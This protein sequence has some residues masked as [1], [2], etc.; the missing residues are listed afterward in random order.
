MQQK[1]LQKP[2]LSENPGVYLFWSGRK[3]LYIGKAGNLKQRLNSYWQKNAGQK[4]IL[5]LAE[6]TRLELQKTESEIEA[7][8]IEAELIKKYRP[9]Y[10]ILMRDDKNYFYV[11][12]TKEIFP[13]IF[14]T[15][16][17]LTK[18]LESRILNLE[19]KT[20]NHHIHFPI[21]RFQIPDSR[22]IGPFTGGTALKTTLKLLRRIF[23]YCTCKKPHKRPC[24]NA[25]IGRCLGYCCIRIYNLQPT[26]NNQNEYQNNIQNIIA[27]LMGKKQK[28]LGK[29]KKEMHDAS[30]LEQYEIARKLRDQIAGL[31]DVFA[32]KKVL[33]LPR[34]TSNWPKLQHK[35]QKLFK[36]K[37]SF[38]RIEAYDISNI[39]GTDATG[40]MI[41]FQKGT[42]NKN[43]YRKFKIKSVHGANDVAMIK[44]VIRRRMQH[45]EWNLPTLIVIDGGKP[46]LRTA[47]SQ[48]TAYNL[49]PTTIITALAKK[50]EELYTEKRSSPIPLKNLDRDI[51][52]LF[53]TV[54][55]EA[56]RFAKKYHHKLRQKIFKK[57]A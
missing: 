22:F 55:D 35:L 18:N 44:E 3:P 57:N 31:E 32:H 12:I 34:A 36:T 48:L 1:Q 39:S 20:E 19:R 26:T 45:P 56:H 10:N 52:H 33:E 47:L 23:P 50:E 51:L 38:E 15:H 27:V 17:P 46:Q 9:K 8:I 4:I 7:L 49:Q 42:P 40:S 43:E 25:E 37:N 28:L 2:S 16:Q 14:L 11:G 5:L 30:K 29:L 21:S 13:K 6:A 53:Q 54:R 24:L 41:V